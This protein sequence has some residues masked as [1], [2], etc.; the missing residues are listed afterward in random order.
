MD[1][2]VARRVT[3]APAHPGAILKQE[4]LE[5]YEIDQAELCAYTGIPASNLS[6]IIHGRRGVTAHLAW[7]LGMALGTTPE[8]W[9]ALQTTYDLYLATPSAML[10]TMP[11]V[12]AEAR[13]RG[14]SAASQGGQRQGASMLTR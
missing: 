6:A 14:C 13:G 3:E 10:A 2:R 11:T 4:F 7:P 12:A 5:R 8:F 1:L 9:M